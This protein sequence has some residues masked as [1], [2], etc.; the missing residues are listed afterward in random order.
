MS[1]AEKH[2]VQTY[3][4]LFEGLS[5]LSKLEL[6]EY[7]SKSLKSK[8]NVKE[9]NFFSSFGTFSSDKSA[10]DI[11]EEIKSSRKFIHKDIQF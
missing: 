8:Q 6:I 4:N 7:L 10:E 1:Y 2:I 11:I 9:K 5:S 3:S